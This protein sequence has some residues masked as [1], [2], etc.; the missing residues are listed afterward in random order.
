MRNPSWDRMNRVRAR[1][2]Q[3]A[4]RRLAQ[5]HRAEFNQLLVE[6][7]VKAYDEEGL[8]AASSDLAVVAGTATPEA[9]G[10]ENGVVGSTAND[11]SKRFSSGSTGTH[12]DGLPD[13]DSTF[14]NDERRCVNSGAVETTTA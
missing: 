5:L 4:Y 12:S 10:S 7:R 11:R 6:E 1:A 8:K 3:R 9:A 14:A 2:Y 13:H